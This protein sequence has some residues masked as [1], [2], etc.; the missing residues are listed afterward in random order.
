MDKNDSLIG[1]ATISELNKTIAICTQSHHVDLKFVTNGC[2]TDGSTIYIAPPP[3]DIDLVKRWILIEAN[4]IH[5]SWHIL[6]KSDFYLLKEFLKKY[7]NK[8]GGKIPFIENIAKDIVNIIE[9]ARIEYLGKKRFLGNKDTIVFSNSYWLKKRPDIKKMPDWIKFIEA[10]LQIAICGGIKESINDAK[11]INL[12]KVAK[13]YLEW[14]KIQENPRS[15]FSAG[16]KIIDLILENFD[17]E[18]NYSSQVPSPPESIKFNPKNDDKEESPDPPNL[19]NKLKKDL[20]KYENLNK[21]QEKKTTEEE[22]ANENKSNKKDISDLDIGTEKTQKNDRNK[23]SD[24]EN[25]DSSDSNNRK[26]DSISGIE[27]KKES[28]TMDTSNSENSKMKSKAQSGDTS[29]ND[30]SSGSPSESADSK[31]NQQLDDASN[32]DSSSDSRSGSI[33]NKTNQQLESERV[34]RKIPEGA[35]PVINPDEIDPLITGKINPRDIKIKVDDLTKRNYKLTRDNIL[36]EK[37]EKIVSKLKKSNL[38]KDVFYTKTYDIGVEICPESNSSGI[39]TFDSI[40]KSL[41][42]LIQVTINQFKSLF[43]IG[44]KTTNKLKFGRLDSHKMVTGMINED[45]HIFKK[46]IFD[47]GTD[48]IAIALLIDQS[49]SMRGPKVKNAQKAAILFGEVLN[50][51]NLN[52]A[53]YGWSDINYFDIYIRKKIIQTSKHIPKS[54]NIEY[55]PEINPE[56]FTLF[57]YKE[58]NEIYEKSR[59]KLGLIEAIYDNSDHNAIE[60]ISNKLQKTKKRIKILMVLSDGQPAAL[61]YDYIR[62]RLKKIGDRKLSRGNIGLNMSRQAIENAQKLGIQTIC[63]SIDSRRNYQEQIYGKSNYIIIDPKKINE[64]PV[65][66]ARILSLILRRSG[67]KL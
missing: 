51:L 64:L 32:N 47:K 1:P 43:K 42:S 49:G 5:E 17:L 44:S 9:D 38:Y 11:I 61:S 58:F 12:L 24:S 50:S 45:P 60:S 63:V 62:V 56:V 18:G 22:D 55:P 29:N 34:K 6:F 8:Y 57:C 53:I 36:K 4:T 19:P 20:S 23:T 33:D 26:S 54:P 14:A 35:I 37:A 52:F 15:S 31:D 28:E 2:Y 3:N 46:K 13:F 67:V 66:V 30:S 40:Y 65:K 10:L 59:E 27:K 39:S 41:Q 48:E 25:P 16:E 7:K 21:K